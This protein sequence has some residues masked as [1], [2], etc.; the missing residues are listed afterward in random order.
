MICI[1]SFSPCFLWDQTPTANGR[2]AT[3]CC[4]TEARNFLKQCLSQPSAVPRVVVTH[5]APSVKLG[6][7]KRVPNI[8][9]A[10]WLND[11]D[12]LV[13]LA[14]VWV[15]GHSHYSCDIVLPQGRMISNARGVS[16]L[17]NLSN[18][19]NFTPHHH[20]TVNTAAP[21]CKM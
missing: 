9:D 15:S 16:K 12:D 4:F 3:S 6:N 19:P 1:H 14:D 20:I 7:P 21:R 5:F 8:L 13:E 11:C 18:D 10:Y 17:F 2:V